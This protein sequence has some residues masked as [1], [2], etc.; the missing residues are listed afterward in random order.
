MQATWH[1]VCWASAVPTSSCLEEEE[2]RTGGRGVG[3]GKFARAAGAGMIRFCFSL[4]EGK[5]PWSSVGAKE[6]PLIRGW[7]PHL[8]QL[9]HQLHME[10]KGRAEA[11][12][13]SQRTGCEP[14]RERR[15]S[16]ATWEL[17][18]LRQSETNSIRAKA[19]ERGVRIGGNEKL[20]I[21]R[22]WPI[23]SKLNTSQLLDE[24]CSSRIFTHFLIHSHLAKLT[25]LT[26]FY[27]KDAKPGDARLGLG[28]RVLIQVEVP[29]WCLRYSQ[30]TIKREDFPL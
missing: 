24:L 1:S 8:F 28:P 15:R 26:P 13:K 3:W 18:P 16:S 23:H 11:P 7:P 17:S 22:S 20:V 30:K 27:R 19:N 21:R 9:S 4:D 25:E 14:A 2:E 29:M 5:A 10:S 6:G 12:T